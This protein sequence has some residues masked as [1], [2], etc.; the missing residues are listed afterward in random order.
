MGFKAHFFRHMGF[1][2]VHLD[3]CHT[4]QVQWALFKHVRSNYTTVSVCNTFG[5]KFISVMES[6]T[7]ILCWPMGGPH[8]YQE[9]PQQLHRGYFCT[10]AAQQLNVRFFSLFTVVAQL[11]WNIWYFFVFCKRGWA[12]VLLV[13][14]KRK[15]KEEPH[16]LF[17]DLKTKKPQ[18]TRQMT[19]KLGSI[20]K[21]A[22]IGLLCVW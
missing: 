13:H 11:I 9:W 12:Q 5:T 6:T 15:W 21:V 20:T 19:E 18:M 8:L 17:A 1:T 4:H 2:C 3:A 16:S 22:W 7:T 14:L 10:R